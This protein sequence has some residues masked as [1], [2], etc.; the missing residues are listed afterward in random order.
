MARCNFSKNR[1][2]WWNSA[3]PCKRFSARGWKQECLV[4]HCAILALDDVALLALSSP[5]NVVV[6]VRADEGRIGELQGAK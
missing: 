4:G 5:R 1:S 3:R 2:S 6:E